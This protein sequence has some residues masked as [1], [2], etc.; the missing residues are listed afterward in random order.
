MAPYAQRIP[1]SYCTTLTPSRSPWRTL[2]LV[3]TTRSSATAACGSA[4]SAAAE[5]GKPYGTVRD[6]WKGLA[7][8]PFF[9]E[10]TLKHA[11]AG[12]CSSRRA[13][14]IGASCSITIPDRR[15]FSDQKAGER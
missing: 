11:R 4:S 12:W 10:I 5:L 13:G 14:W 2:S 6:W 9:A 7:G 3:P 15:D 1:A 8:G